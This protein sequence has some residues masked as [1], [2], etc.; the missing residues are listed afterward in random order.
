MSR[1]QHAP[2]KALGDALHPQLALRA[3]RKA[4]VRFGILPP[5]SGMRR[6]DGGVCV[7]RRIPLR[8]FFT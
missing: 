6:D 7:D 4:N 5:Q 2:I 1:E 3:I 8:R